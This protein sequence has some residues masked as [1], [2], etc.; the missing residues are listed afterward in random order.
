MSAMRFVGPATLWQVRLTTTY[1][2]MIC[3]RQ[4]VEG[5]ARTGPQKRP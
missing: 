1:L 5:H 3:G 2:C 4:F